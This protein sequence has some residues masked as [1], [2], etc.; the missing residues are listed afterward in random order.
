ME[1][2]I[3]EIKNRLNLEEKKELLKHLQEDVEKETTGIYS[4]PEKGFYISHPYNIINSVCGK[5]YENE[6]RINFS[7]FTYEMAEREHRRRAVEIKL[8][9][10]AQEREKSFPIDWKD[11]QYKYCIIPKWNHE[12]NKSEFITDY[13]IRDEL[14]YPFFTGFSCKSEFYKFIKENLTEEEIT[15]YCRPRRFM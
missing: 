14:P 11:N 13:Y 6:H 7:L 9:R 15:D 2:N 5:I 8:L 10:L 3:Y 4:Q 1:L 12:N